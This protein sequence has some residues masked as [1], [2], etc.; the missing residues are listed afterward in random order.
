MRKYP[1][2]QKAQFSF[3]AGF[4]FSSIVSDCLMSACGFGTDFEI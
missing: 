2:A 4:D 3:S 1:N